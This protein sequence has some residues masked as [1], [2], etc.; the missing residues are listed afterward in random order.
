MTIWLE[1]DRAIQSHKMTKTLR[2]FNDPFSGVEILV[3][4]L[5]TT[6]FSVNH[7]WACCTVI[8]LNYHANVSQIIQRIDRIVR[9]DQRS[10]QLVW[11][12]MAI[13]TYSQATRSRATK[14]SMGQLVSQGDVENTKEDLLVE[15][16]G[17]DPTALDA[18]DTEIIEENANDHL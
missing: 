3:C 7:R 12:L 18:Q 10:E 15:V 6:A 9:I 4:S 16:L 5:G 14:K 1:V 13:A 11:M 8:F 17:D 2:L